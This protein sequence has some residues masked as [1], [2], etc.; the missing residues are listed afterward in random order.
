MQIA[1]VDILQKDQPPQED[2]EEE[3]VIEQEDE[4]AKEEEEEE[5]KEEDEEA[6]QDKKDSVCTLRRLIGFWVQLSKKW[7]LG[8][9]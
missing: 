1:E 9:L 3:E 7:F 2:V 5:E 8:K 6:E 4:D